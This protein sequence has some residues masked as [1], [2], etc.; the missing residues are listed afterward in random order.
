M[1]ILSVLRKP[2]RYTFFNAT[3]IIIGLNILVY[4][5]T[6]L[7]RELFYYLS[8]CPIYVMIQKT[9]WQFLTYMF[10]HD[11]GGIQHLL[12]NMLGIFFFGLQVE[13]AIGSKEFL[14]LYFLSGLFCGVFSFF[15]YLLTKNYFAI[16]C[17]ASG[18]LYAILLAYAVIFPRSK[19]YIWGLLPISAPLLVAIYA[20][21]EIGSQLLNLKQGVAHMTHLAGFIFAYLYFIVRMKINPWKVWKDAYR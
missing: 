17:G 8:L 1:K 21:L 3:F 6:Y 15:F 2:F 4:L 10:V 11:T 5:L 14:L 13:K 20:G 7:F 12:F 18:A 9:Y 19:I 16:L